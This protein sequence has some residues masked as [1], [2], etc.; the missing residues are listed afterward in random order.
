MTTRNS[1]ESTFKRLVHLLRESHA[2]SL[3]ESSEEEDVELEG[4]DSLDAQIDK[5]FVN[6]ESEAKNLQSEGLDF[7][8]MT[9]RFLFEAE[10]EE[11]EEDE[12][13]EESSEDTEETK[14]LTSEDINVQSFV[15]DVM[16][17]VDNYDTL[18]EVQ[19]TIL[20]RAAKYLKKNYDEQT[21][22]IFKEELLESYGLEI[23]V[24][25]SEKEDSP[26]F[27]APKAGAAGPMGG[28]A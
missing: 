24:S 16:R 5:F 22:E 18:L 3:R 13:S 28:S 21:V 27:Q 11:S 23:G 12:D 8:M 20:R 10:E 7:R 6:Y 19:N 17:L 9:R 4:E 26:D 15:T 2:R 25:K 1:R 14:K